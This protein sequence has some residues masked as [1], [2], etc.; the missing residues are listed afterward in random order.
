M[1]YRAFTKC[2]LCDKEIKIDRV[3][4]HMKT[5]KHRKLVREINVFSA[6]FNAPIEDRL[7]YASNWL[8][9]ITRMIKV[10]SSIW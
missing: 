3:I 6:A 9:D 2:T 1:R 8:S 10:R 7:S 4:E 5:L